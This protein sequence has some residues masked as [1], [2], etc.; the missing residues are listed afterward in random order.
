MLNDDM[1]EEIVLSSSTNQHDNFNQ[2]ST[3][4]ENQSYNS[5]LE[6]V[7]GIPEFQPDE[8]SIVMVVDPTKYYDS[9]EEH[10][11]IESVH[12]NNNE[13]VPTVEVPQHVANTN[14]VLKNIFMCKHCDKA[15][16]RLEDCDYHET[17][18]HDSLNPNKCSLCPQLFGNRNVM[19]M[20]IKEFHLSDK[21]YICVE[22]EKGFGR[23]SDLKKHTIVH[24]GVRPYVCPVC[25]KNFSRNTNLTKHL[26]IHSGHKPFV[27]PNCPRSFM[28]KSDLFRHYNIH[29]DEKLFKCTQCDAKFSR[30]DKLK[31]HEKKHALQTQNSNGVK[32]TSTNGLSHTNVNVKTLETCVTQ[33]QIYQM[34]PK[35]A[36][37]LSHQLQSD[38]HDTESMVIALDPYQDMDSHHAPHHH[39]QDQQIRHS[40]DEPQTFTSHL[41]D[42]NYAVPDHIQNME[43]NY[44]GHVTGDITYQPDK[45][46]LSNFD[47]RKYL[48]DQCPNRFSSKSSLINHKNIHL[49]IRNHVC[50]VCQKAFLRKRE[51]ERHSVIH[52]G[53]KAFVCGTCNKSF[54]RKDKLIRHERIHADDRNRLFKCGECPAMY[55][56]KDGLLAHMKLHMIMNDNDNMEMQYDTSSASQAYAL[57][58]NN[59]PLSLVSTP[60][61]QLNIPSSDTQIPSNPMSPSSPP[62][63]VHYQDNNVSPLNLAHQQSSIK[64]QSRPITPETSHQTS[65]SYLNQSTSKLIMEPPIYRFEHALNTPAFFP[66][67]Q[68]LEPPIY[69][70][71]ENIIKSF[72]S[73]TKIIESPIIGK[74]D[75]DQQEPSNV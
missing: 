51:L 18:E 24:T 71:N 23:R 4:F 73:P 21:P 19:I 41:N 61:P 58:P 57:P 47:K 69:R 22:C 30:K 25:H 56:R 36:P 42:Q 38:D 7:R 27:C 17:K 11:D 32:E 34:P 31:N 39:Q 35:T 66:S 1:P 43:Y 9:S 65:S 26:R 46:N 20:H 63:E 74:L 67:T 68:H 53:V 54:G 14:E 16:T 13:V 5:Y 75:F 40:V 49:G 52:T 59:E 62:S 50:N 2:K 6:A 44:P 60:A 45:I 33:Q 72:E 55:N 29:F 15:Y 12:S 10:D 48:C 3:P 64:D 37:I 70:I 28:N 8:N